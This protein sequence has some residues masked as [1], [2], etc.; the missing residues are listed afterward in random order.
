MNSELCS[1]W[2]GCGCTERTEADKLLV[3]CKS[4]GFTVAPWGLWATRWEIYTFTQEVRFHRRF[5]STGGFKQVLWVCSLRW[6]GSKIK[7]FVFSLYILHRF[8]SRVHGCSKVRKQGVIPCFP[9]R[10]SLHVVFRWDRVYMHRNV[11]TWELKVR[12]PPPLTA[13]AW[14]LTLVVNVLVLVHFPVHVRMRVRVNIRVDLGVDLGSRG[15]APPLSLEQLLM[16]D[17]VLV[18]QGVF[19]PIGRLSGQRRAGSVPI[20]RGKT[21]GGGQSGGGRRG[22][23]GGAGAFWLAEPEEGGA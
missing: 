6:L 5:D 4:C 17:V 22:G 18:G 13:V 19:I 16:G 21:L 12:N 2:G 10:V 9:C 8:V 3:G 1:Y 11:L 23:G 15:G 20:G 14:L 7:I